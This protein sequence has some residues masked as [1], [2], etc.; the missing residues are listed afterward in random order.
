MESHDIRLKRIRYLNELMQYKQEG[1]PIIFTDETYI[2]SS[3]TQPHEWSDNSVLGLKKPVSKGQRLI[4][5]H[6][7]GTSGFV[8]NARLIF[9]SGMCH[10]NYFIMHF[11]NV[12][13]HQVQNQATIM[14]K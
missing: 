10:Y 7:G 5:V 2:H 13:F 8:P 9:T 11:Y 4:I 12:L 3:H 1:R 6:A 14:M